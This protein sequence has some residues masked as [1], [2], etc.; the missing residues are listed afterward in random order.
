[1]IGFTLAFILFFQNASSALPG[2][3]A[4]QLRT[5]EGNPAVSFRVAA[6]P[7]PGPTVRPS[8]GSNYYY[9]QPPVSTALTD[10]LGR[11]RLVNVPPGRYFIVSGTTYYPTTIDADKA[12]VITVGPN[13]RTEDLDFRLLTAF[14]GKVTGHIT[15]KP[16]TNAREKAILSGVN[17]E[18]LLEVPISADGAFEFGH[19]PRG[20]YFIDIVPTPPGMGSFRFDVGDTDVNGLNLPRPVTHTVSGKIVVENGPLPRAHL[21]FTTPKS[22]VAGTINPDGTFT[23]KLHSAR[24][25]IELAGM[26]SGYSLISARAGAQD[27]TQSLQVGNADIS[28]LVMTVKAPAQLPHLR[29]KLSGLPNDRAAS[30]KIEITGP[31][32]GT[33]AAMPRPDGS[34]EF[35]ALTPGMYSLRLPQVPE[36][37]PINVVVTWADQMIE[38]AVPRR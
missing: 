34:F 16:E 22:Y 13:S 32:I 38:V 2:T 31:I 12:M 36:L 29:G 30:T 19:V 25:Q 5:S 21:A 20:T 10:S 28:G 6:I 23:A 27:V 14:G 35:A 33:L 3:I 24:H 7:A 37:K 1:M 18:G 4:G 17:F 11:Y 15:P 9:T 26:P 8:D